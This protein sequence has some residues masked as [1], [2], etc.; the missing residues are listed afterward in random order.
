MQLYIL[1]LER[2][3]ILQLGYLGLEPIDLGVE[4]AD[5]RLPGFILCI[6]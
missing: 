1:S 2:L 4:L 5:L 6:T 3:P